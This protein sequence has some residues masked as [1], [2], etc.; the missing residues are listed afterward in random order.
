[1]REEL[2]PALLL[3]SSEELKV[4]FYGD[5]ITQAEVEATAWHD[6]TYALGS[7][8]FI[9]FYLVWY[10]RSF[11]LTVMA[12]FCI[13]LS[14]PISYAFYCL[15]YGHGKMIAINFLSLFVVLGVGADDVF[16][17][18]D[19]WFLTKRH[20]TGEMALARRMWSMYCKAGMAIFAT[21]ATTAASFFANLFSSIGPLRQ[22]GFFMGTCI[23]VNWVIVATLY[24]LV[25]V[26]HERSIAGGP[27]CTQT[28]QDVDVQDEEKALPL[29]Q[30][31]NGRCQGG[32]KVAALM[33]TILGVAVSLFALT[34]AVRQLRPS[35]G[36]PKFF[37]QDSNLGG[38]QDLQMRFGNETGVNLQ[39]MVMCHGRFQS[40]THCAVEPRP[41]PLILPRQPATPI[42]LPPAPTP[43]PQSP[44]AQPRRPAPRPAPRPALPPQ[45]AP[46]TQP[47]PPTWHLARTGRPTRPTTSPPSLRPLPTTSRPSTA[48]SPA[49]PWPGEYDV[50]LMVQGETDPEELEILR[51]KILSSLKLEPEDLQV[52]IKAQ[53]K[54]QKQ[55]RRLGDEFEVTLHFQHLST[56]QEQQIKD[57]LE[58]NQELLQVFGATDIDH[59]VTSTAAPSTSHDTTLRHTSTVATAVVRHRPTPSKPT[60]LAPVTTTAEWFAPRPQ[61]SAPTSTLPPL[62][63]QKRGMT[64]D[65]QAQVFVLFGFRQVPGGFRYEVDDAFDLS[66]PQAQVAIVDFCQRLVQ[67]AALKVV[68]GLW[69][70]WPLKMKEFLTMRGQAWPTSDFLPQLRHFV[71]ESPR[72][73]GDH[74]DIDRGTAAW[75]QLDFN[76][77][78]DIWSSGRQ[79][80]PYMDLWEETVVRVHREVT[81]KHSSAGYLGTP[82]PV[83]DLFQRAEAE[84]RV[85]NSALSSWL[86]SVACALIALGIFT[87]SLWLS[88]IAC[89]AMLS[90]AACSLFFI[91]SVFHWSFG[92]M[93]AVSLIIFCG[94]SV[95]YP[96]HVVQAYV[97]ERQRGAKVQD[98]IGEVGSAVASG[99]VTTCGAAVFLLF[100]QIR[101]F[102][103]FGQVLVVNMVCSLVFALLWIPAVLELSNHGL[104]LRQKRAPRGVDSDEGYAMG[105]LG[106]GRQT[107]GAVIRAPERLMLEV[108]ESEGFAAL[109]G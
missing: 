57:F 26:N 72:W 39:E 53:P 44:A 48:K 101:I 6:A 106:E 49:R 80:Q 73:V 10:L 94:F 36:V 38:L 65:R 86:V 20:G 82:V 75:S 52:E 83:S 2:R 90:T 47:R 31:G 104:D 84:S 76:V 71:R 24:P 66:A 78:V 7:L 43:Q 98:A 17:L 64:K 40:G 11:R 21:S 107:P 19:V 37:P 1:M 9:F 87:Q 3:A 85:V 22:F 28:S 4:F 18:H 56:K 54:S 74:M 33:I 92:L 69:N 77:E 15:V 16:V 42:V 70:C 25:L 63:L 102:T 95:D 96:L 79:V 89:F 14:F 12:L 58:T 100:C 109:R 8:L 61:T 99:C 41:P 88:G 5:A 91:T 30:P 81:E 35:N 55:L 67:Q 97:H 45:P 34:T 93:E 29:Q 51:A 50:H 68:P 60:T 108:D 62:H 13:A 105:L 23:T 27:G 59:Q 46:P 103:R 32:S